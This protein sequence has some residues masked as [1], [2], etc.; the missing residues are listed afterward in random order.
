MPPQY[1]PAPVIL[2]SDLLII[3]VVS[4]SRVMWANSVAILF[5]SRLSILDLGLMCATDRRQTDTRRQTAS[6]LNPPPMGWGGGIIIIPTTD[7]DY[8]ILTVCIFVRLF[9][10]VISK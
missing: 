7:G 6:P 10:W 2:T 4:E 3:K 9:H 8:A 1:A 5:F